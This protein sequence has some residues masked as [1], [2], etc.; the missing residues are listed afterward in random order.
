MR[1]VG[2]E[3]TSLIGHADT[4]W[5]AFCLGLEQL[6]G[7]EAL[8]D[9]IASYAAGKPALLLSSAFPYARIWP[10]G[11]ADRRTLEDAPQPG[12]VVRFYPRP[13]LEPAGLA[14]EAGLHKPLKR[15]QFVSQTVFAA[16]I[17][18]QDL[19]PF[20]DENRQPLCVQQGEAWLSKAELA[21]LQGWTDDETE[22]ISLWQTWDVPRVAVDRVS[23]ASQ[24]YQAG[25]VSFQPGGGLWLLASWGEGWQT[26]GEAVWQSLGDS[27]VGGE[28]SA[29]HGRFCLHPLQ[30]V[31]LPDPAAGQMA[32]N[33][34]LFWPPDGAAAAAALGNPQARYTLETRR[35]YMSTPRVLRPAGGEP[36]VGAALR[37]K[38]VRMAG[39]GSLLQAS[40]GLMGGLADVTPELFAEAGGHAVLRYGYAFPIVVGGGSHG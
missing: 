33:L 35:G 21:R 28:R 24:V 38:A 1:S 17:A 16:W 15:I 37:R 6:A 31:R 20:L 40:G 5:S 12:Q 27:G 18:G 25:R 13:L 39:E 22:T 9:F 2:I 23:S 29:G 3:G 36:I 4:L 14:E 34:A 19:A 11:D 32:L 30:D 10:D 8:E 7:P 26:L